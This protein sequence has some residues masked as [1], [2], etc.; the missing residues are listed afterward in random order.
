MRALLG[1]KRERRALLDYDNGGFDGGFG[2]VV[3][4]LLAACLLLQ[5]VRGWMLHLFLSPRKCNM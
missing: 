4:L 1:I 5:C 2:I 3:V